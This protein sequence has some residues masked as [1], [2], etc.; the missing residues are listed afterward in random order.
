M[1]AA[2]ALTT[3]LE[4]GEA[5][6]WSDRPGSALGAARRIAARRLVGASLLVF[7]G[8]LA[9]PPVEIVMGVLTGLALLAI[10]TLR[11]IARSV[12][13]TYAVTDRGAGVLIEGEVALRFYLPPANQVR[14]A[15]AAGA[16]RGDIVLGSL[17]VYRWR[18]RQGKLVHDFARLEMRSVVFEDIADPHEAFATIRA[19]CP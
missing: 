14:V 5:L 11:D 10:F 16:E 1:D 18:L 15:A 12:D 4:E 9:K 17:P 6:V 7:F 2:D 19:R 3:A 13:R 8:V